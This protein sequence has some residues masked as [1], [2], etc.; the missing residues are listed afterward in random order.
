MLV[1]SWHL[2]LA[3]SSTIQGVLPRRGVVTV[4]EPWSKCGVCGLLHMQH[5]Q[6][7]YF[8]HYPQ[9]LQWNKSGY[10]L[11]FFLFSL[12]YFERS[13]LVLWRTQSQNIDLESCNWYFAGCN[14][15]Q[16]QHCFNDLTSSLGQCHI[17][18][19]TPP[20]LEKCSSKMRVL[21]WRVT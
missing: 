8:I 17:L 12:P 1:L 13:I 15:P 11:V 20:H 3:S 10:C 6:T 4:Q 21:C 19:H 7:P 9:L 14:Y 2:L 16:W 5:I 18:H